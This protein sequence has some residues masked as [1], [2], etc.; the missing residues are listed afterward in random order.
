M[1][2]TGFAAGTYPV[3]VKDANGCTF[4]TS[5]IVIDSPG[6]TALVVTNTNTTCGNSNGT[7]TIGAVTGGTSA[8]VYSF[9]GGAFAA[10]TSFTALAAGPYPVIVK[11]ANGCTF[12]TS[13]TIVNTPGPTAIA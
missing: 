4:T 13:T 9:N 6:P 10:T 3:I 1:S 2:Y 11:D 7:V 12:T 8:Y 5:A